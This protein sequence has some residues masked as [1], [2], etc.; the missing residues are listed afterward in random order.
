[1][2]NRFQ[3]F[4]DYQAQQLEQMILEKEAEAILD[5]ILSQI[6]EVKGSDSVVLKEQTYRILD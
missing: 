3:S 5:Q 1:M 4:E 6:R 2:E